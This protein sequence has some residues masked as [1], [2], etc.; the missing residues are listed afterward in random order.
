MCL[1]LCVCICGA[2][3]FAL[4]PFSE[5]LSPCRVHTVPWTFYSCQ[6][7]NSGSDLGAGPRQRAQNGCRMPLTS[8]AVDERGRM[9]A[10]GGGQQAA[11][12]HRRRQRR[13]IGN[14][15]CA[16]GVSGA[17]RGRLINHSRTQGC[18]RPRPRA[19]GVDGPR[20]K[21]MTSLHSLSCSRSAVGGG[22]KCDSGPGWEE[23]ARKVR[24]VTGCLGMLRRRCSSRGE[25]RLRCPARPGQTPLFPYQL[26]S[27][28]APR[29]SRRVT[30]GGSPRGEAW[31]APTPAR[32]HPRP[33]KRR[34]AGTEDVSRDPNRHRAHSARPGLCLRVAHSASA[35]PG[36]Q[37]QVPPA[38]TARTPTGAKTPSSVGMWRWSSALVA[39]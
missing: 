13:W 17:I 26:P 15:E 10:W 12:A 35:G 4:S 22:R 34:N 33:Q 6:A 21:S 23:E 16:R 38:V 20:Q 37:G 31:N 30:P 5:R 9:R 7:R 39:T 25:S 29:N 36:G 19:V 2:S 24:W 1:G 27:D 28:D 14:F 18:F 32:P 8:R 3:R 11:A